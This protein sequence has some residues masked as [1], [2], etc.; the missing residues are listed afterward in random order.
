MMLKLEIP[1]ARVSPFA[2]RSSMAWTYDTATSLMYLHVHN[3]I[4][5]RLFPLHALCLLRDTYG[6]VQNVVDAYH[7]SV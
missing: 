2:T 3:T 6:K 5:Y 7:I 1:I 4:L